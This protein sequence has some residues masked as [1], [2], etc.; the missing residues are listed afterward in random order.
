M[1]TKHNIKYQNTEEAIRKCFISLLETKKIHTITIKEICNECHISRTSFYVHY[2]DIYA[3][4]RAIE[5][6][7]GTSLSSFII[8]HNTKEVVLTKRNLYKLFEYV[9]QNKSI[10]KC[11]FSDS[12]SICE[13]LR[14]DIL[15]VLKYH[16]IK[17]NDVSYQLNFFFG[18]LHQIIQLWLNENCSTSIDSIVNTVYQMMPVTKAVEFLV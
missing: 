17:R 5:V 7:F 1:N 16:H 3:L 15:E 10:F 4:S 9:Q 11:V 13:V 18:G 12:T 14:C 6:E 8:D 2:E